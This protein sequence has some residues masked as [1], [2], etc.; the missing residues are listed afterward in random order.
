M[1]EMQ[2]M[3]DISPL[4]MLKVRRMRQPKVTPQN[5]VILNGVVYRIYS[6]DALEVDARSGRLCRFVGTENYLHQDGTQTAFRIFELS[7]SGSYANFRV[8]IQEQA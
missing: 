2:L 6:W 1:R 8:A 4:S 3:T 7:E 5:S